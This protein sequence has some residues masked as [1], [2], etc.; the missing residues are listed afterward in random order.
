MKKPYRLTK[1]FVLPLIVVALAASVIAAVP[2]PPKLSEVDAVINKAIAEN[3]LPGAVLLV[4][5][6]GRIVYRK[7]YGERALVP[8][9]ERM[10][11]GTIFDLASLTKVVATAPSIMLLFQEGKI[12]LSDPVAKY[13]P[14]FGANGKDQITVRMLMTHFSGLRPDPIIPP[15][16][17]GYNAILHIIYADRPIVPP[18][19]RFIYSDCNFIVLGELVHKI[20]GEPLNV[21]AERHIFRPLGMYHTRYLP[22]KSWIHRIAPTEEIDLPPG[23]K[24]GSGKGVML[25]GVV[26]DPTARAMG[27]VA[28]HAGLFSDAH[29]L[30][31]YAQMLLE[32]GRIPRGRYRGRNLLQPSVVHKMIS[33]QSPPWSPVLQGLGW[34]IDSRFSSNRGELF[35]LGSYG[36]TGYTGTSIWIDPASQT[37][38]ILLANTVHPYYRPPILSLRSRVATLVAAALG[39][40]ARKGPTSD[41][42]R[43]VGADRPYDLA[44][45]KTHND[46]TFTGIDILEQEHFAPLR[47][48]RVGLITN[49]TG[50]DREGRRTIDVLDHAPGV[51]LV[52]IFTPEHGLYGKVDERYGNMKDPVT[53]LPVYSLYGKTLRPTDK[54]LKGI[55]ALV[56]DIQDAGVRFYTFTTTMAYGMEAAAKHHIPFIVLDRPNPL[57]GERIEGPMLDRDRLSFVGFFPEPVIY[58]MT[59]GELAK[60][61]NAED[62]IGADLTVVKMQNW[63][64]RDTFDQ[65]GLVWIPPSPNLRTVSQTLLYPGIEILQAGGV[66]V[67]RGT[68]TPFQV[69]GAPY[70]HEF[71]PGLRF[72]PT[73]FTPTS[74]IF[75]GQPCQGVELLVTDRASVFPMLTGIEIA[76]TLHK[77]YPQKFELGRTIQLLGSRSTLEELEKGDVPS[78]IA[79]GWEKQIEQF[80]QMRKKYLLYS[81]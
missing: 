56:F 6:R 68:N 23:A 66:S 39:A 46:Q 20:S 42:W 8:H 25:R 30:A 51:K 34:D 73:F 77:F 2:G 49:Q 67:G 27:G 13:L 75:H 16:V 64:R 11:T 58:G 80:R 59:I 24:P 41:I 70:I 18:G 7:A 53:G 5:H 71:I 72:V 12:R 22:P 38:V 76:A 52:A 79:I 21:F 55:N 14:E 61:F 1:T 3:K 78:R 19:M 26:E 28:G 15:G 10:T 36:H 54:E 57:G 63:H 29:D 44:G 60:M 35:P 32:N 37:F 50:M 33:V 69:L 43:T 17:K 47:G 65:T 40:G 4:G 62:H 74:G 9:R 81:N 31:I 48:K 45:I